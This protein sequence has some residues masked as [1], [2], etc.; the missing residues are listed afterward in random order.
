MEQGE[1]RG[2]RD[3]AKNYPGGPAAFEKK[4]GTRGVLHS[5]A[6]DKDDATVD[7]K[8]GRV[9]KQAIEDTGPLTMKRI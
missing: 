2:Y 4:F 3:F 7:P 9:G 8:F 5:F 6:T 1:Y